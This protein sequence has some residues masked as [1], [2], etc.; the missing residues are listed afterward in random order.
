MKKA[1][2]SVA[3]LVLGLFVGLMVAGCSDDR[4]VCEVSTRS[5]CR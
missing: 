3:M 5:S 1:V 4:G 2:V